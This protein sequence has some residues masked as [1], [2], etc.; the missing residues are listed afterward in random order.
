[1]LAHQIVT[2]GSRLRFLDIP[3]P[4]LY[5]SNIP[6]FVMQPFGTNTDAAHPA[7]VGELHV[8]GHVMTS[9][10]VVAEKAL[11]GTAHSSPPFTTHRSSP[12]HSLPPLQEGNESDP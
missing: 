11:E 6:K 4:W 3:P 7:Y 2:D 12:A 10:G 5:S 1:M 8:K 9:G